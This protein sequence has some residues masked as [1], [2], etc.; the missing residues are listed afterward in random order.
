MA[1]CSSI[2]FF[3]QTTLGNIPYTSQDTPA[4]SGD[5]GA[6]AYIGSFLFPCLTLPIPSLSLDGTT[7]QMN[8]MPK[9]VSQALLSG[10]PEQ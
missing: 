4:S 5:L 3:R 10:A 2:L 9:S 7:S 8:Y 6:A 1:R